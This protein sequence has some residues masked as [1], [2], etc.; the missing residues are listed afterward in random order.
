MAG[1]V[2]AIVFLIVGIISGV[3]GFS[4]IAGTSTWV[5]QLLFFLLLIAFVVTLLWSRRGRA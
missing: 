2:W 4:G 1:W 5:A 3:F